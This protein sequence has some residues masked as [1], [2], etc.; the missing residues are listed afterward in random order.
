[1]GLEPEQFL[2]RLPVSRDVIALRPTVPVLAQLHVAVRQGCA[3]GQ[4]GGTA[5]V[6]PWP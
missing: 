6:S 2:E 5:P 4:P 3:H 1:M